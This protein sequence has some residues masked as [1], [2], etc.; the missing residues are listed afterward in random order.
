M[1]HMEHHIKGNSQLI[2]KFEQVIEV[3]V[4]EAD[5]VVGSAEVVVFLC[6]LDC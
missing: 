4:V 3:V 2:I 6:A 1:V 5:I